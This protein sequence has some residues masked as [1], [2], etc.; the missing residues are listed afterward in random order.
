M[1][2][3]APDGYR[4]DV[5]G[6]RAVAVLSVI[7]FHLHKPLLPGEFLGVDIFFVISGYLISLRVLRELDAGHFSMA[8]FYR[9]R[10]KRI[11]PAMLVVI[12]VTLVA[13]QVLLLPEDA[14]S[15]EESAVWSLAPLAN[16][17]FWLYRDT[18]YF[19]PDSRDL[20]LLHL[21]SL[22][23]EEQFYLLWPILLRLCHRALRPRWVLAAAVVATGLS[24][25]AGD[26]LYGRAPSFVYYMLP[27]RAGE[28]LLGA[29]V[30]AL[31]LHGVGRRLAPAPARLLAT[32]GALLTAASLLM[33]TED[34]PFPGWRAALPTAGVALLIFAGHSSHSLWSRLLAIRPLVWIG[35]IAY[36]AYLWHWPL[37]S[38]FHYGY[39]KPGRTATA[40]LFV[41]TMILAWLSYRYV[42]EPTRRSRASVAQV[43]TRQYLLPA[44]VLVA[45]AFIALDPTRLGLSLHSEAY[46]ARLSE[47]RQERRAAFQLE[48]VCQRRRLSAADV[49]DPRC[50]LGAPAPAA[51]QALLWGDSHA[52]RY[53]GMIEV[54]ARAAGFRFRNIAVGSC[55]P[56]TSD[57][58][59]FVTAKR[60]EDCRWSLSLV[61]PLFEEFPVVILSS[62]SATRRSRLSIST[63]LRYRTT[64]GRGGQARHRAGSGSVDCQLRPS[65]PGEGPQLSVA[66]MCAG[67][68]HDAPA[69]ADPPDQR[70][71]PPL[72]GEH[73][74]RSVLRR[75]R[76]SL[77]R[78]A[79]RSFHSER[80]ATVLRRRPP[81][82]GRID[83]SRREERPTRGRA[84]SVW[85]RATGEPDVVA[86]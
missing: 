45:G 51:P 74:Q 59:S 23:V 7:A 81:H 5:D 40:C 17:Y 6:L 55:P 78:R 33:V 82:P 9:R 76:L 38:F 27:T 53:I 69:P 70:P 41:L 67:R 64:S 50:V 10:A 35:L 20:P 71:A 26:L 56:L 84:A 19:A 1:T 29:M 13:S 63:L 68:P 39:G 14:Q 4:P 60:L 77:P 37:L 57:P 85:P 15:T 30:A 2:A 86:S 18:G 54:F 62:G 83:A 49:H 66:P 3:P 73:D 32:T 58:A 11:A 16:V 75:E 65:V 43:V 47:V 61:K 80:P 21:W 34:Q 42:E 36:S 46:T 12:A 79:V 25:A 22:G 72:F 8:E 52:A 31:V 28:F 24:F 44:G 48:W